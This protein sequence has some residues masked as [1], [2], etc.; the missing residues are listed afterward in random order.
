MSCFTHKCQTDDF[1]GPA[2]KSGDFGASQNP[3]HNRYCVGGLKWANSWGAIFPNS[4]TKLR[5][6]PFGDPRTPRTP[7][8]PKEWRF[9]GITKPPTQ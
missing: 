9:W 4:K 6:L 5:P 2:Q 7:W 8:N 3:Q 1:L